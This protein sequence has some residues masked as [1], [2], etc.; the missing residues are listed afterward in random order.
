[1]ELLCHLTSIG[2]YP[3]ARLRK[4]NKKEFTGQFISYCIFLHIDFHNRINGE[5]R[6][7]SSSFENSVSFEF[8]FDIIEQLFDIIKQLT[9]ASDTKLNHILVICLRLFKVHL[10]YLFTLTNLSSS[11][12]FVSEIINSLISNDNFKLWFDTLLKLIFETNE[13]SDVCTQA[14]EC[15]IQLLDSKLFSFTD[16]LS[17]TYQNLIKNKSSIL[18]KQLLI[19]LNSNSTLFKWIEMLSNDKIDNSI[20]YNILFLY[21]NIHFQ[22]SNDNLQKFQQIIFMQLSPSTSTLANKYI[23]HVFNNTNDPSFLNP[24]LTGLAFLTEKYFNFPTIQSIITNALPIVEEYLFRT[25][26]N[27]H[28]I[29]WLLATMNSTLIIGPQNDSLELEY[30]DKLQSPLFAG[31]SEK[32]SIENNSNISQSNVINRIESNYSLEQTSSDQEFL[33]LI[34]NSIDQDEK[35]IS[36][37]K[38]FL[39][40]KYI[41]L[42]KSIEK[43]AHHSCVILFSV[44]LKFYPRINLARYELTQ[45]DDKKPHR[46]LLSLFEYT[47]HVFNLFSKTK[48]QDGNCNELYEQ[49]KTNS[50]FLLKSIKESDLIPLVEYQT[51]VKLIRQYSKRKVKEYNIRLIG[52]TFLA[53]RKFKK[54]ILSKRKL[55]E[56]KQKNEYILRRSIED[57][58][59]NEKKFNIDKFL[60]CLSKQNQRALSRLI[61]KPNMD[62]TYLENISSINIQ[63]KENIA[64]NYYLII[65]KSLELLNY[66]ETLFYLINLSYQLSDIYYLYK[67]KFF[68]N[69]CQNSNFLRYNW[70]RLTTIE[71]TTELIYIYRTLISFESLWQMKAIVLI[72][73]FLSLKFQSIDNLLACLCI[74]GSYIHSFCLGAVV[75]IHDTN[76]TQRGIIVE[77]N[78]DSE[79]LNAKPFRIQLIETNE[80]KSFGIDQLKLEID[81]LPPNLLDL[82]VENEFIGLL[83]DSLLDFIQTDDSN[84]NRLLLLQLKRQSICVLY[85]L[86]N[87]KRL[88]DI[89]LQK[90]YVSVIAR[91]SVSALEFKTQQQSIDLHS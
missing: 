34:Y 84:V 58:I 88:V 54:L 30:F 53:C 89:F 78:S 47:T 72:S 38:S 67:S 26:H 41:P 52:N 70:F 21:L 74:L 61:A 14:S 37:M 22:S 55:N 65:E 29:S 12:P 31:G 85:R 32:L 56:I 77:I 64:K 15:L 36:K 83:F 91:L 9:N 46:K 10:K 57:F 49:I 79:D 35:L 8:H 6:F 50:L 19:E 28:Y 66:D 69:F 2:A 48:G 43:Q 45:N 75:E 20:A 4:L 63:L 11:M 42:Q 60:Q 71:I 25:S 1:E 59:F 13:K 40:N 5:Q 90:P 68:D 86:L 23:S 73:N 81:V 17:F 18:T 39:K 87:H 7:N 76:E 33:M 44:Y 62:W 3:I 82:P 16:K 24:I 27:L 80:I 51:K